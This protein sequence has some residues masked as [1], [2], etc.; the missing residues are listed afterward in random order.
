[1]M[2]G[3]YL[4]GRTGLDVCPTSPSGSSLPDTTVPS[5]EISVAPIPPTPSTK[6]ATAPPACDTI[7]LVITASPT[8]H[9][10]IRTTTRKS[11]L[12]LRPMMTLARSAALRRARRAALSSETSSSE[13]H[14]HHSSEAACSPSGLLTRKRPLCLDYAT[15]TSSSFAGPSRKRSRSSATSIPSTVHTARALSPARAD[16]LP[17]HKRY[18]GTSAM[19]SYESS[20]E[21]SL[22]THAESD[23]DSDILVDIEAETAAAAMTAVAIVDGLGIEPDMEVFETGFELGL[24]VVESESKPEEAEADDEANAK[25]QL[26]GTIEIRVDVTTGIDIPNDLPMLDTIERLE[27]VKESVQGMFGHM[28]VIPL[29]RIEDIEAGQTE[30][31]ARNMIADGERSSLLERVVA[32]KSSNTRLQDALGIERVRADSLQRRLGYVEDEF[33]QIRELHAYE[34]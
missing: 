14:S 2:I 16:L 24:A 12:G 22:E 3:G 19:H 30:Q 25:I 32:L 11:T 33:K 17:P 13:D 23:M 31:Q 1:M 20:D 8:V 34:S 7:T 27:Q 5:A 29:Q 21:G 15:S 28:L 26:E 6:I 4:S 18:R 10:R 9:S